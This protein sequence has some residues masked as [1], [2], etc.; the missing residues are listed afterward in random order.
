[1]MGSPV[2]VR[3]SAPQEGLQTRSFRTLELGPSVGDFKRTSNALRREAGCQVVP[4]S[5]ATIS[6]RAVVTDACP[7]R[8]DMSD[9]IEAPARVV[10][11][12]LGRR[13]DEP[14]EVVGHGLVPRVERREVAPA[15]D[16]APVLH[17]RD[18]DAA[19]VEHL[20]IAARAVD[21]PF[22]AHGVAF[23]GRA[24]QLRLEVGHVGDHQLPVAPQLLAAVEGLGR[25]P[26]VLAVQILVEAIHQ[27][28]QVMGVQGAR[29]ALHRLSRA[30]HVAKNTWSRISAGQC[31][32]LCR[33]A[34]GR[35]QT[36]H[37]YPRDAPGRNRTCDLWPRRPV[38]RP[39]RATT[40]GDY[41]ARP[42]GLLPPRN[43]LSPHGYASQSRRY[44]HELAT[45]RLID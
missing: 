22:A 23:D 13:I 42:C 12:A 25:V 41:R 20:P 39:R 15:R 7:R 38:R 17:F 6:S 1:M 21:A 8:S 16:D 40:E 27:R 45:T 32:T 31:S 14:A 5:S 33:V 19:Q 4:P 24:A 44:G 2:R 10:L 3:A 11:R 28:V 35:P 18:R 36:P 26:E 9:S 37:A 30:V 34:A 29:L 43:Q